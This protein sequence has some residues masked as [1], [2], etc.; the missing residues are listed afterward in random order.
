MKLEFQ[1][2]LL[3]KLCEKKKKNTY[4]N[5]EIKKLENKIRVGKTC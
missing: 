3:L 2:T 1:D 5:K 4:K